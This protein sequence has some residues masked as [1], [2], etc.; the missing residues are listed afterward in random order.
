M[1]WDDPVD[2]D[3]MGFSSAWAVKIRKYYSSCLSYIARASECTDRLE[4]YC[5]AIACTKLY[6]DEAEV[7]AD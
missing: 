2:G 1:I 4:Q 3:A 7:E 5:K 6:M